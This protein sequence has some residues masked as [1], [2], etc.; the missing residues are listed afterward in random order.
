MKN[1]LSVRAFVLSTLFAIFACSICA[2]GNIGR[3]KTAELKVKSVKINGYVGGR[4]DDCISHRVMEQDVDAL[5]EPFRHR[6]ETWRWQSEF[7]GKW[8]LGAIETYRYTGN[9]ALYEKIAA[10]VGQI[11]ETQSPDGY[12]GNYAPEA[13]LKDWDIWGRK[14]TMLGLLS[15]Y[16][17]SGDTRAL[18]AASRVADH[19]ISQL[20]SKNAK[21]VKCGLYRGMASSS[22]LEPIMK[23]YNISGDKR[24]LD[25]A[26]DIVSQWESPDGPKLVSRS[27][28]PVALRFPHPD[29]KWFS[30]ENGAKAYE[31]MSC[32]EGL[33]EYYKVTGNEA[34]YEAVRKSVSHIIEEEINIAGSGSSIECWYGG[35]ALQTV[36]T[37]HTMETCVGFTWMQLCSRLLKFCGD[38][39]YADQIEKTFYNAILGSM[40]CDGSQIAK[41]TPLEGW[42]VEGEKQ[43][44]MNINCCNANGPRAFAMIPALA[45]LTEGDCLKINHYGDSEAEI[46]LD[47]RNSMSIKVCGNYPVSGNISIEL[48]PAKPAEFTL[49][50]RIPQ[51]SKTTTAKLI[52][53]SDTLNISLDN[54]P[55][56]EYAK[57]DRKWKKGDRI[58]L[59]LDLTPHLL[60]LNGHQAV[61]RGPIVL[62][63]DSRFND[64]FVDE[65]VVIQSSEDGSVALTPAEGNDFAWMS[66]TA[67]MV[68]G[69]DL[70]G[71]GKPRQ[72]HLCDF[73]SAGNTWDKST[74][75]KVWLPKTLN[76]MKGEYRAYN[77]APQD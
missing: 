28:V 69:A 40:K 42:R 55:A 52:S 70:E 30:Y 5:V 65:C 15:W 41:Y 22:V 3:A 59:S 13:Q 58:E 12:I 71:N 53:G 9:A 36:P 35:K 72:I 61:V 74:R 23:L 47:K 10:S 48:S 64:G 16:E 26:T 73:A 62:A 67:P 66:F 6:T 19:L 27:D 24:Y 54:L 1:N 8:T 63:R 29:T 60:E 43:C 11:I 31:M 7:W 21:I 37:Y 56:G 38:S 4:I 46:S 2:G 68:A 32:Y 34:Y 20:K 44:H 14:Y 57:V 51:W 25:F 49:A 33:L 50:L 18:S 17:L 45:Y 39:R 75:Y 76:V 77:D